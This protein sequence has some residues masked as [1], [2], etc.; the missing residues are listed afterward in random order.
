M[1][2]L[3]KAVPALPGR[4]KR[5]R[6]RGGAGRWERHRKRAKDGLCPESTAL[7]GR[8]EGRVRKG[9]LKERTTFLHM[10]GGFLQNMFQKL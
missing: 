9:D 3:A 4:A 6:G 1:Q 10:Q 5:P 8:G 7:K 2:K